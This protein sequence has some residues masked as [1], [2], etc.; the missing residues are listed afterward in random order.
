VPAPARSDSPAEVGPP[1]E[2]W[3]WPRDGVLAA[4]V[5]VITFAVFANSLPNGFVYDDL[6]IIR[7][8]PRLDSPM[9][10][11]KFFATSYWGATNPGTNLYRPLTIMSFALDRAIFGAGPAPVHLMNVLANAF[12]GS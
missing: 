8:N 11:R 5:F 10:L 1:P 2:A 9:P 4:L 3:R 6:E 7:D 12:L